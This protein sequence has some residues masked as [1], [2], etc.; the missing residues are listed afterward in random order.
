MWDNPRLLNMAAGFLV[1]LAMLVFAAAGWQLVVRSE[2]WPLREVEVQGALAH[3]TRAEIEAALAG[4]VGG[5][6]FGVRLGEVRQAIEALPWV[7]RVGV[8]RVWPDR[9]EV[10]IEEH[11]AL[12]RWGQVAGEPGDGGL[13]N[14]YGERFPARTDERLPLFSGPRGS[15]GEVTRAY[16]RFSQALAPLGAHPDQV[17]LTA[18]YAWQLRLDNGLHLMLGRD[19]A[20]AQE[21]LERFVGVLAAS[22][23]KVATRIEYVDLRYPNGFAL[24]VPASLPKARG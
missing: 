6:F 9:L 8:R 22:Q 17:L 1:G 4:R 12:A 2:R 16:A 13:V 10:T 15:E 23:G 14:I 19:A 7:R 20:A 3:T 24:R 5:N 21:R 18:R 11:V